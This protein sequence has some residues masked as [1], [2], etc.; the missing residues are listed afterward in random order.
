M[1]TRFRKSVKVAPG[2]RVNVNKQSASASFGP[3]GLKHTISTTGKSRTTVGVPGTGVS[4]S[5]GGSLGAGVPKE[6]R[7]TSPKSKGIAL[8]LCIFL[9][10]LGVHRYYV[11]KLGTGVL[12]TFTAGMFGIG[13]IVDIFTILSGGFYDADGRVLRSSPTADEIEQAQIMADY[14]ATSAAELWAR[15][16]DHL[17][18]QPQRERRARALS[19]EL[20]PGV[21]DLEKKVATFVGGGGDRYATTLIGCSCPDFVA[22]EKPCKHMYW[23]AH[24]LGVDGE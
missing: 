23:L 6:Q 7:P 8:V 16:G 2:V 5:A 14:E 19:G 20:T 18:Y 24:Q 13:W 11:G 1:S 15:W 3:Q 21:V 10:M 17:S 12:W 22:R 4:Y 9:G